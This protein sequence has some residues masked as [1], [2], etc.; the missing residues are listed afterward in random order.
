MSLWNNDRVKRYIRLYGDPREQRGTQSQLC[1]DA[2][3]FIKGTRV[4]DFGCG[5]GHMVPWIPESPTTKY[6]GLDSSPDMLQA[7][8]EFWPNLTAYQHDITRDLTQPKSESIGTYDTATCISVLLHLSHE[9]ALKVIKNMWHVAKEAIVFSM[10]T[11]GDSETIRPDG[12]RI[13]NQGTKSVIQDLKELLEIDIKQITHFH[14]SWVYAQRV[15]VVPSLIIPIDFAKPELLA[16]TT[17]FQVT[18]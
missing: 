7:F 12:I 2:S 6:L 4:V 3:N 15:S 9:E 14:Q 17:V 10:E 16:R 8:K 13:R 5:M 11:N 18:K 1:A